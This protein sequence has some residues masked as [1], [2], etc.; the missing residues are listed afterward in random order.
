MREIFK[1]SAYGP[2]P[3]SSDNHL[4]LH[5]KRLLVAQSLRSDQETKYIM[6]DWLKTLAAA[7]LNEGIQMMVP[8]YDTCLLN[9]HGNYMEK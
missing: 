1:H 3:A 2:D 7:F 5:L 9:L 8:Q 6:Q 4:Y